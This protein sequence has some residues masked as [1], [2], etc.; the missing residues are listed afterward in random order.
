M[1]TQP[2]A[3]SELKEDIR[4][5]W[6][7]QSCGTDIAASE[8][9]S[10]DYFEEIEEFRYAQEPEIFP[11]AEF[12]R[13]RDARMLEVGVGA[14]TDFLQWV[15]AGTRANGIDLTQ[16]GVD[17][18]Q[19]RLSVYDLECE[20]LSVGDAENIPHEDNSFDLV[21]SWGV[22]HHS[23]DT[24]KALHEIARVTKKGGRAKIMVY[25]RRSPYVVYKY[26]RWGLM[27]GKP[28]MSIDRIMAEHQ[29][30]PG[31][32]AY[33]IPQFARMM[34]EAGFRIHR[35]DAPVTTYDLLPDK[36]AP[37]RWVA[38]T[39]SFLMGLKKSGWFLRAEGIKN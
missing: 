36:P 17:H 32:K 37:V 34:E 3:P 4:T 7:R 8:K 28:F 38:Y 2:T 31:T 29:E 16:E 27:K 35:I 22:I 20:S 15:R 13:W 9:F 11:F 18:V 26:L 5:Y 33:S 1:N 30:S 10:R 6:N 24:V 19:H 21:Y 39:L 25:N 12:T 23:P 14:G